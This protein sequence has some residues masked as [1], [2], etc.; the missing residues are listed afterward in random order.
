MGTLCLAING[1]KSLWFLFPLNGL[2]KDTDVMTLKYSKYH[3]GAT[4]L[5]IGI[6]AMIGYDLVKVI[7]KDLKGKIKPRLEAEE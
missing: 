4:W 1:A 5:M 2:I 3:D 7:R 6:K